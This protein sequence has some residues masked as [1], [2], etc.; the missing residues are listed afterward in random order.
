MGFLSVIFV[1][2]PAGP[3]DLN[4]APKSDAQECSA[5]LATRRFIFCARAEPSMTGGMPAKAI[6]TKLMRLK[7]SSSRPLSQGEAP[8]FLTAC[9]LD[10]RSA[11]R[12]QDV[13]TSTHVRLV[14]TPNG[15]VVDHESIVYELYALVNPNEYR[16]VSCCEVPASMQQE[17]GGSPRRHISDL[18]L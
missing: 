9:Q 7:L 11:S 12:T 5:A 8:Q 1:P 14:A 17:Q 18:W 6:L 3:H 4:E 2:E 13:Y 16:Q 15:A 10:P